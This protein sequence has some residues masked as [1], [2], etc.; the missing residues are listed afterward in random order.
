MRR[1]YALTTLGYKAIG[2]LQ[3]ALRLLLVNF[4]LIGDYPDL[5]IWSLQKKSFFPAGSRKGSE[6]AWGRDSKCRGTLWL[7]WTKH[8]ARSW[9][10]T[11]PKASKA[12]GTSVLQ[13]QGSE[14][15]QQAEWAWTWILPRGLQ[16]RSQYH[17]LWFQSWD[18]KAAHQ[19]FWQTKLWENKWVLFEAAKF[20]I[21]CYAVRENA[22]GDPDKS[23]HKRNRNKV[24]PQRERQKPPAAKPSLPLSGTPQPFV[25]SGLPCD[26]HDCQPLA[27]LTAQ[28]KNN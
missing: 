21:I 17:I 23:M 27:W 28:G 25:P 8:M 1:S 15:C 9:G 6:G 7:S 14:G 5:I 2:I 24:R 19:G 26:Q 16:I 22:C 4:E 3:M 12:P 20:V 18:P 13:L 11:L 10:L